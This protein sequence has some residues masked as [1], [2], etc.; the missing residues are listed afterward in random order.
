MEL[1]LNSEYNKK[2][3]LDFNLISSFN[4][5]QSV[6]Y[7]LPDDNIEKSKNIL[8]DQ[9]TDLITSP[10]DGDVYLLEENTKIKLEAKEEVKWFLNDKP[11][12]NGKDLIISITKTGQYSIKA[13]RNDES[14]EKITIFVID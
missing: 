13:L 7:G 1:L 12:G 9:E 14:S 6:Q 2:T 5:G 11:M 3:D 4:D 8:L 10:H